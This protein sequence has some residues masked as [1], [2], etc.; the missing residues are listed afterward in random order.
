MSIPPINF[1]N[2]LKKIVIFLNHLVG[3]KC[4]YDG[5]FIVMVVGA[6]NSRKD[7]HFQGRS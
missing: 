4:I 3:N 5:D 7:Y 6:L 2:G 1:K